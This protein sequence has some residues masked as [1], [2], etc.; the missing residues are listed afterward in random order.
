MVANLPAGGT[1]GRAAAGARLLREATL[2]VAGLLGG[3]GAVERARAAVE[4]AG[5]G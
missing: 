2:G 1:A 5:A 3:S 4:L